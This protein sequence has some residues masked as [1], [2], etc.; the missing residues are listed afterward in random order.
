MMMWESLGKDNDFITGIHI[1][2]HTHTH[3]RMHMYTAVETDISREKTPSVFYGCSAHL[4]VAVGSS[5]LI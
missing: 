5:T 2:V 3:T 1:P 4:L